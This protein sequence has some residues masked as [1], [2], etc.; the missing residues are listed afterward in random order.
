MTRLKFEC[1]KCGEIKKVEF[2]G[3]AF[4]DRLL[5]G[6][7]FIGE[8]DAKSR[9]VISISPDCKSY[10]RDLNQKKWLTE[11][12]KY[13]EGTDIVSCFKCKDDCGVEVIKPPKVKKKK[14]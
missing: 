8:L 3:Y 12:K 1:D 7:I 10:F 5:E 4:G 2:D 9:A 14:K 6:V 13:L 11:A